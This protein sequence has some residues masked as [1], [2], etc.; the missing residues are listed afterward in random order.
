MM[1]AATE[2]TH[3]DAGLARS[4]GTVAF[5]ATLV[6]GV[7]GGGIFAAPAALAGSVGAWAP[8]ALLACGLAMGAI[9]LCCAEAGSRVPSSGGIYAYV[10]A[11]FGRGWGFVTGLVL[12]MS[13]V[14]AAAGVAAAFADAIVALFPL[15]SPGVQRALLLIGVMGLIVAVNLRGAQL[16]ARAAA[17]FSVI[18][19]APLLLFIGVGLFAIDF[20]NLRPSAGLDPGSFGR[21]MILSIFAFSGIETVL[22]ASGEV[23][24]PERTIPRA[25]ILAMSVILLLYILIQIVAQ[26]LLGPALPGAAE[27]L[28]QAIGVV[29]P[30]LV[31]VIAIGAALSRGGWLFSDVLGAPRMPFAFARDGLLPAVLGRVNGAQV[32][33]NAIVL[34]VGLALALALVG[35]FGPLVLLSGLFTV[36]I[37][38]G[39][40]LAAV[41]LRRDDVQLVGSPYRAPG[42]VVA[43][44]VGV[45]SMVALVALAQWIE[46]A[47]LA[48]AI[49]LSTLIYGL[50]RS[51]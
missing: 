20:D 19:L 12:W 50:R 31:L 27:P 7:I 43:A 48:A 25:L 18:K 10:E 1:P 49:G 5:A 15:G 34:H 29:R 9:V 26:G 42:L 14:L 2:A 8:L 41:K 33:A 21:A 23:S 35:S 22:G 32:P 6:N 13:C 36:P 45:V 39:A 47:G 44:A 30:E 40:C 51:R 24:R 11:A 3:R 37:Y 46:I 4:I 16:G 28:A 17:A 38:V